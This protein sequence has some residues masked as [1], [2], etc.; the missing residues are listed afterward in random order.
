MKLEDDRYCFA[1]GKENPIGLKLVFEQQDGVFF[2]RFIPGKMHQ[3]Y[4]DFLHGGIASTV[5]DE[6]M[7][8]LLIDI[9]GLM[10]VTAKMEVRFRKP[11][12]IESEVTVS[13]KYTGSEGNFHM[14]NGEIRTAKGLLLVSATGM[15]AEISRK[16]D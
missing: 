3:G 9:H 10:V 1:C 5:L 16:E 8:R 4:K 2:T 12:P 14:A 6:V 13:A 7:A 15:F 11:V